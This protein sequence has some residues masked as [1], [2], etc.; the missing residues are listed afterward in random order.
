MSGANTDRQG[1][2]KGRNKQAPRARSL[3]VSWATERRKLAY[4]EV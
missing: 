2:Y 3:S 4:R 1:S